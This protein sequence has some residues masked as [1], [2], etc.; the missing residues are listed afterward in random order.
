MSKKV[1]TAGIVVIGD[2]LLS[3]RTQDTNTPYIARWLEPLG[4][5]V[6]EARIIKD[7]E[8]IIINTVRE[9]SKK[10][11]Y[12]FKYSI[13]K[14][15]QTKA[16]AWHAFEGLEFLNNKFDPFDVKLDGWSEQINEN[17]DDYDEFLMQRRRLMAQKMKLYY[18]SL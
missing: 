18:Y 2:E 7:H 17:I 3:G 1:I 6:E 4:I 12:V 15:S 5:R 14:D 13:T 9:F 10:F 16:R 8:S 11:T